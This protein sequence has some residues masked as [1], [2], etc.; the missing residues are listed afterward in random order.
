MAYAVIHPLGASETGL[1]DAVEAPILAR[2]GHA[3]IYKHIKNVS[4]P[5]RIPLLRTLKENQWCTML[6]RSMKNYPHVVVEV[7]QPLQVLPP[8]SLAIGP[9]IVHP[10]LMA[11]PRRG[12][13]A[14]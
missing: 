8:R 10:P 7:H 13:T 1:E 2:T 14:G 11:F 5:T 12:H 6:T 9:E 3:V 4:V